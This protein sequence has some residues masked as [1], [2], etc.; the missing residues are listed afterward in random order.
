MFEFNEGTHTFVT[1][2]QKEV[3][4]LQK[5]YTYEHMFRVDMEKFKL[6]TF[7]WRIEI[8]S[9]E[10]DI[11]N[12]MDI[13]TPYT[14]IGSMDYPIEFVRIDENLK[15]VIS[16]YLIYNYLNHPFTDMLSNSFIKIQKLYD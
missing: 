6:K 2:K 15:R 14:M 16:P 3:Q 11:L 1:E 9:N 10:H 12:R 5:R 13:L 7:D 4:Q 8:R